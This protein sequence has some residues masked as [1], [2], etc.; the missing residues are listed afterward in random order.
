MN[1]KVPNATWLLK[2][3]EC[4]NAVFLTFNRVLFVTESIVL[5][6]VVSYCIVMSCIVYF[7]WPFIALFCPACIV[8]DC[9][10]S[11]RIASYRIVSYTFMVNFVLCFG[12]LSY[13]FSCVGSL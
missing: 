8:F 9:V 7:L 10:V 4:K 3:K 13:L 11:Y 2:K 12:T 6:Y 5:Y 1:E